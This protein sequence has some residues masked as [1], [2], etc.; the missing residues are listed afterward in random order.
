MG[1]KRRLFGDKKHLW[2]Y[3]R[4][5]AERLNRLFD[6]IEMERRTGM[7]GSMLERGVGHTDPG[8]YVIPDS[9][10]KRRGKP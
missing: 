1:I 9:K 7:A 5:K 6:L 3:S 2:H 8:R 4:K 10:E